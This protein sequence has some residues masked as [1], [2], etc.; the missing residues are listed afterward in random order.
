MYLLKCSSPFYIFG[1]AVSIVSNTI[2]ES[3]CKHPEIVR[4]SKATFTAQL[5]SRE[6][7]QLR[8]HPRLHPPEVRGCIY[9]YAFVS[10]CILLPTETAGVVKYVLEN[11]SGQG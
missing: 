3:R 4:V 5:L 6:V 8:K 9:S 7:R 11:Q 10:I 1:I 2:I